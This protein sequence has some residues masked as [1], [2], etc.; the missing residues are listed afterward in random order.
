[1][2]ENRL[3]PFGCSRV[4]VMRKEAKM[5]KQTIMENLQLHHIE[6]TKRWKGVQ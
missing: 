4:V 2:H 1:M 3:A 6:D 5:K